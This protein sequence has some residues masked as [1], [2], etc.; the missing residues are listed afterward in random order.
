MNA[1]LVIAIILVVLVAALA[2]T[3]ENGKLHETAV[4]KVHR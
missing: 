4:N 1:R 3:T 2:A